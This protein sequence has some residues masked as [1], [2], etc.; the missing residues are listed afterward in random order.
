MGAIVGNSFDRTFDTFFH[1]L[2]AGGDQLE[3]ELIVF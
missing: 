2:V 3:S 1:G